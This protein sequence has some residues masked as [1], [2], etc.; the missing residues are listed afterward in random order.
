[1]LRWLYGSIAVLVRYADYRWLRAGQRQMDPKHPDYTR[2]CLRLYELRR[3]Y[4]W[5]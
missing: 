3:M 1:M 5:P 4:G 2:V